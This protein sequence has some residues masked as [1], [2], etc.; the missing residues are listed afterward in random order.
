MTVRKWRKYQ[1]QD[2]EKSKSAHE[3]HFLPQWCTRGWLRHK[4]NPRDVMTRNQIRHASMRS[5][6]VWTTA[7][8]LRPNTV[9]SARETPASRRWWSDFKDILT[10]ANPPFA[11]PPA[12]RAASQVCGVSHTVLQ[13]Q[14]SKHL[15]HE[16]PHWPL[17][18]TSFVQRGRMPRQKYLTFTSHSL[19]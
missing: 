8:T 18:S 17:L 14:L 9:S 12:W 6:Q 11:F 16:K 4:Q 3:Q 7:T 13:E 5:Q 10:S 1:L 15:S 19:S 2:T